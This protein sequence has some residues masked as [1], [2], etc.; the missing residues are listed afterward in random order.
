MKEYPSILGCDSKCLGKPCLA[1]D[2]HDGSNLRFGWYPKSGW[3]K[4][5]TRHHLFDASDPEYGSAV[6]V[7]LKKYAEPIERV[8]RERFRDTHEVICFCEFF[9]PHSFAG[10]HNPSELEVESNDPKDLVLFDVNVHKKGLLP[11]ADF[12][13]IFGHLH[14][15]AVVY[16]GPLDAQF[17]SDVREGKYPV[18]EGVVCK[19]LD[20]RPPHGIWMRKIKTYRYRDELKRRFSEWTNFWE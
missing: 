10:N 16:T 15:P 12:L 19:G 7:F 11:P 2:K 3:K 13:N 9:G 18:N 14:T 20:G 6:S 4:F 1:F 17:I 8:I 5:G